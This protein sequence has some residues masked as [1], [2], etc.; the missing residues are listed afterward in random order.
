[1]SNWI[2]SRK[3]AGLLSTC[4][5]VM[6]IADMTCGPSHAARVALDPAR[7]RAKAGTLGLLLGKRAWCRRRRVTLPRRAAAPRR[8][9]ERPL[10]A[11]ASPLWRP[12]GLLSCWGRKGAPR[13]AGSFV[14]GAFRDFKQHFGDQEDSI[15][16]RGLCLAR[17]YVCCCEGR[18]GV[19]DS[20]Y[21]NWFRWS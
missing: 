11:R 8:P 1:M 7:G 20:S 19:P 5:P 18:A 16:V 3:H 21:A 12:R 14:G 17:G 9:L 4:T 6:L 13:A 10:P 2:E 15:S